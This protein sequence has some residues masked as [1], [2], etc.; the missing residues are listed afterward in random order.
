MKRWK[1]QL[2]VVLV[3]VLLAAAIVGVMAA[4]GEEESGGEASPAASESAGAGDYTGTTTKWGE[5]NSLTGVSAAPAKTLQQGYDEEIE[6]INANGGVLGATIDSTNLDDKSDMSASVAAVTQL[7]NQEQ[8]DILIGPFPQMVATAARS[9]SEKGGTPHMLYAPPTIAD[10]KNTSYKWSFLCAAGPDAC[11]DA[12]LVAA[13]SA[14]Y[15]NVV[16]IADVIP[17]HQETLVLMKEY[18]QDAGIENFTVLPDKWDLAAT[19]VSPIVAKIAAA[20]KANK[21]DALLIL[22]NPI[23]VPAIQKGLK[24]LGITTPVIGSAAG[25]SPAIFLQGPEAVE[26]FTALGVGITN[27]AELPDGYPGKEDMLAFSERFMAKYDMPPDFYAGF[28]YDAVHLM[29]NAQVA[30]GNP[31]DKEAVRTAME[32]TTEWAGC[33]GVFTY[34][35]T[36]HVGIHGGFCLWKVEGGQFK[37]VEELN[38]TGLVIIPPLQ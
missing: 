4:C 17:I 23:H 37:L 14:G 2:G 22:S 32:N 8:V 25:T 19:D 20:A 5:M 33:Q 21:P 18:Y 26:G 29:A 10:L 36:D 30:A 3:L 15:K 27:P 38:P 12:L 35:A 11:A 6:Y 28:A 1:W 16:A 7:M 13:Q 34:S 24:A 31:T 9:I